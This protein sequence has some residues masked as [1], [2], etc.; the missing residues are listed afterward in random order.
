MHDL[1]EE[2]RKG[3]RRESEGRRERN[4]EKS[5]LFIERDCHIW[6]DVNRIYIYAYC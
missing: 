1:T 3:E 2:G 5:E 6:N 4:V